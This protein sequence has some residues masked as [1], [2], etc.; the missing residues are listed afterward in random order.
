M[1][2]IILHFL[3]IFFLISSY[4]QYYL[5]ANLHSFMIY[6]LPFSHFSLILL[7]FLFKRFTTRKY[8]FLMI[9]FFIL[10]CGNWFHFN[11]FKT[12]L[13]VGAVASFIATN[14]Y[15][16]LG[17][18][19]SI[20]LFNIVLMVIFFI[21]YIFLFFLPPLEIKDKK[22]LGISILCLSIIPYII[23]TIRVKDFEEAT[24]V[25]YYHPY[26]RIIRTIQTAIS[27]FYVF[28]S[29]DNDKQNIDFSFLKR[30]THNKKKSLHIVLIGE[31]SRKRNWSL[32]GFNKETNPLLSKRK[33]LIIFNNMISPATQTI[34]SLREIF[35]FPWK[36]KRK[37]NLIDILKHDH[38]KTYWLSNQAKFGIYDTPIST[39][40]KN[41]DEHHYINSGM[42]SYSFDENLFP[43][44]KKILKDKAKNKVI[45]VHLMGSH[46]EYKRRYPKSFNK[47]KGHEKKSHLIAEYNN[48][49]LYSDYIINKFINLAKDEDIVSSVVYFSDHGEVLYDGEDKL[50]GHGFPRV[51][52]HEIEVPFL[53]WF[54]DHYKKQYKFIH[55][56]LNSHRNTPLSLNQFSSLFTKII[57]LT[58]E[59]K[60]ILD[61]KYTPLKRQVLNPNLKYIDFESITQ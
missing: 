29:Q 20:S 9:P 8:Y 47:F 6:I 22:A 38:Q 18:L 61:L 4:M 35:M 5:S 49:L 53:F 46:A 59:T 16:A 2:F 37:Y 36:T 13:T 54:S 48:S 21:Y 45:F 41:V 14:K 27:E 42:R 40:V 60:T 19:T 3:G 32:Y 44:F 39:M 58:H 1:A 28:S 11:I 33:D 30:K 10:S 12:E 52:T 56:L 24:G 31:S 7:P 15:E 43:T 23:E 26:P 25:Y 55:P 34:T 51:R 50:T 57:G 17:Y